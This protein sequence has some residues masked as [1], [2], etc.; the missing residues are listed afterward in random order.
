MTQRRR[1]VRPPSARGPNPG[2]GLV[3]LVAVLIGLA[4]IL[5]YKANVGEKT[6]GFLD[7]VLVD[8]ELQLP[9][10]VLDRDGGLDPVD[11]T[12]PDA[13]PTD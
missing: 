2:K 10:S 4:L 3:Q 8:P 5:L 7:Q 9:P 13:A 1:R 6:A 12:A 11:A